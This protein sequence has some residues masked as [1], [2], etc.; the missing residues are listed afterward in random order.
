MA[1]PTADRCCTCVTRSSTSRAPTRFFRGL[2]HNDAG[3]SKPHVVYSNRTNLTG[4][5]KAPAETCAYVRVRYVSSRMP[6]RR[7]A[8]FF[9]SRRARSA[10]NS[11]FSQEHVRPGASKVCW[12][13]EL[14]SPFAE[15]MSIA[16]GRERSRSRKVTR[17]TTCTASTTLAPKASSSSRSG[18]PPRGATYNSNSVSNRRRWLLPLVGLLLPNAAS[19]AAAWTGAGGML[20]LELGT[21]HAWM[22]VAAEIAAGEN[23]PRARPPQS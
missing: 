13:H 9:R 18:M 14:V 6:R 11:L 23:R 10:H 1:S 5:T 17:R 15:G 19:A 4:R 2:G 12:R 7:G 21:T 3:P 22:A 8:S 16:L 20:R